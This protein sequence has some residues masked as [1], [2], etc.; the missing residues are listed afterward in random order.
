[1]WTQTN[2][3]VTTT[4]FSRRL[5]LETEAYIDEEKTINKK[6]KFNGIVQFS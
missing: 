6:F 5:N 2:A 4:H 3:N 1:M